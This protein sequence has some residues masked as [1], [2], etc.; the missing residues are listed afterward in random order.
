M[1]EQPQ[2]MPSSPR[3]SETD[4]DGLKARAS[5]WVE[6]LKTCEFAGQI[7][8]S[9]DALKSLATAVR[10]GF[11]TSVVT[12]Q[13][14]A[15][16]LVFS[17]NCAY[18]AQDGGFWKYLCTLLGY[19]D[20]AQQETV[21]GR[22]IEESL[23]YFGFLGQPRYGPF[24]CVGPLLE[25]AGV[26]V[27]SMH[28]FA[29]TL[30]QAAR[31][32]WDRLLSL[33]FHEFRG[34]VDGLAPGTYLGL[35]LKDN[36]RTGWTF[37]RDVA[38]SIRQHE[39][40]LISSQDLQKLPGYRPGF[41]EELKSHLKIEPPETS[42]TRS[43]RAPL[44]KLVFDS[45]TRQVQLAFDHDYVERREYFFDGGLV[46]T[47]RWPCT[48]RDDFK[49]S[50]L[51]LIKSGDETWKESHV[52]GFTPEGPERVAIFHQRKGYI[53]TDAPVPLGPCFLLAPQ[54]TTLPDSLPA[55]TDF[56]HVS[57]TD[58]AYVFWQVDVGPASDLAPLGYSQEREPEEI[59]SWA[60]YGPRLVG[61]L[62]PANVFVGK[63]PRYASPR[64][65]CSP[66]TVSRSSSK[67]VLLPGA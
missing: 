20:T 45:A 13:T 37:A 7:D 62:E 39:R 49:R 66:K 32:D 30:N 26:T 54:G 41:W 43:Q 18:Y 27:R 15:I 42:L 21:L 57:I 10:H 55:L 23:T 1:R 3:S 35:F 4:P 25:Q 47:S 40:G 22:Q 38:R 63:L 53:P 44:P 67:Q 29:E 51:I 6:A 8:L 12:A 33:T 50:Y 17:V 14:H 48:C 34:V 36:S 64:Q 56:E 65:A 2:T 58:A 24:R 9:E 61:A 5:A 60:S 28:K 59:L 16:R 11:E 31:G 52:R 46:D 19:E